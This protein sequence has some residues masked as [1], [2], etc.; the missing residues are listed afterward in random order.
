M[1]KHTKYGTKMFKILKTC[2]Q[3]IETFKEMKR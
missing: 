2:R 1:A 3:V